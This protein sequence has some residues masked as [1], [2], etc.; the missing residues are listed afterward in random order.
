MKRILVILLA[1]SMSFAFMSCKQKEES[2]KPSS[3]ISE[4]KSNQTSSVESNSVS[5]FEN[6][7]KSTCDA[8][9]ELD[10]EVLS[11]N[12]KSSEN[13]DLTALDKLSED[14]KDIIKKFT[15]NLNYKVLSETMIDSQTAT[16]RLEITNFDYSNFI[17]DFITKAAS[18]NILSDSENSKEEIIQ[19]ISSLA[20]K[21][22]GQTVT[23]TIDVQL[24][25]DNNKWKINLNS[26]LINAISG[27]MI[28]DF[29][30]STQN[31]TL[32]KIINAA[33]R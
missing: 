29:E 33:I 25:N 32:I 2:T 22:A 20:E 28:R 27:G 21:E 10:M 16:V 13:I 17:T 7:F 26:E 1:I 23:Q 15:S 11:E 12:I 8:V 5:T 18:S 14:E 30:N 24:T 3:S 9:K 19:I 31:E 4:V 6:V